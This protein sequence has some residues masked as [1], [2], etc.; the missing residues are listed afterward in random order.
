MSHALQFAPAMLGSQQSF[1][2]Y[3]GQFFKYIPLEKE[4]I[5]L[6]TNQILRPRLVYAGGVR[7][8]LATGFGAD[9]VPL[10][11]RFF[12]GGGT[13]LRGFEQNSVGPIG[14]TRQQLGGEAML[15]VNNELRFPLFWIIDGV[16]FSDI[17]NVWESASQ[18]SFG[19]I[20]KTAGLGLRVRAPWFLLRLDY[21]V[22][23]DQ[24]PGESRGRLFF[25]IGQAF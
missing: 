12:A 19:D 11:E 24:R 10:S 18:F 21:G 1:V 16:G 20:R 8:G 9:A 15:V 17:G 22:K 3:F 5:E 13:T 4:E 25:S 6:F 2:K 14:P 7:I 23:L